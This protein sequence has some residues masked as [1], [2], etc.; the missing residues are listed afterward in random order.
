MSYTERA[1]PLLK[2]IASADFNE[3]IRFTIFLLW[4][5]YSAVALFA[6]ANFT[7][8]MSLKE[9]TCF[10]CCWVLGGVSDKDDGKEMQAFAK[11]THR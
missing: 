6:L 11:A 5:L 9:N 3:Y 2:C 8:I 10:C 4:G 7:I 1:R